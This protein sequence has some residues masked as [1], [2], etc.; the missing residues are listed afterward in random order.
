MERISSEDCEINKQRYRFELPSEW[1][2]TSQTYDLLRVFKSTLCYVGAIG[3]FCLGSE[4][5]GSEDTIWSDRFSGAVN[6]YYSLFHLGMACLY[7]MPEYP[8]K[9]SQEFMFP[10]RKNLDPPISLRR[11]SRYTHTK[12]MKELLNFRGRN[13][14]LF[15]I[16]SSLENWIEIR[17]LFSYGPWAL[18]QSIAVPTS[19]KQIQSLHSAP[20]FFKGD[21]EIMRKPQRFIPLKKEIDLFVPKV[22]TLLK[23]YPPFLDAVIRRNKYT[24]E[25]AKAV[26]TSA[27]LEGPAL[28]A[29]NVPLSVFDTSMKRLADL[30]KSL[31]EDY[32][33]W[34]SDILRV[35]ANP[36]YGKSLESGTVFHMDTKSPTFKCI[37]CGSWLPENLSTCPNCG[38]TR[39]TWA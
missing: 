30:L 18:L 29:P 24:L 19:D 26:M 7:L 10:D 22:D 11:L 35:L 32:Q 36:A 25:A 4:E 21:L 14:Y 23:D 5:L 17:E 34:A 16:G 39:W 13:S 1:H 20:V 28:F 37:F 27:L 33:N 31:G 3:R 9:L 6:V 38:A 12:V 15:D 8:F 2:V